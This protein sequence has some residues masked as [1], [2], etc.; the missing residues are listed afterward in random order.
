MREALAP[1]GTLRAAFLGAN[2]VQGVVNPRTKEV[3]GPV[4]DVVKELARRMSV[5]FTISGLEGVPAVLE[6]VR[7]RAA[8]IGFLAYDPT[9]AAQVAFTQTYSLA[10][11]TY[12][13]RRD[14]PIQTFADADRKG[15]R[16][17]VGAGDSVDLF[18]SRTLKEAQLVRPSDRTMENAVRMLTNG[19]VEAYAAN[20]QRL[21]EALASAP[22]LRLLPGSVLPVQQSMVVAKENAAGVAA[23]DRFI[24]DIRQSGFLRQAVEGAKIAGLE[25]APKGFR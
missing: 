16:I 7:T 24:D 13:V 11:N 21:T 9:R 6:A 4:A 18:L 10:H 17:G 19:E 3:T 20:R 12:M 22:N 15:V 1:S 8:D 14:S 2:P 25:V 5:P 23:L